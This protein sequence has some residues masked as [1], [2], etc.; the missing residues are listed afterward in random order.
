MCL[1]ITVADGRVLVGNFICLDKQGNII[2][3]QTVERYA[4]DGNT[5]EVLLGQ[6]LVPAKQ[7]V[8]CELEILESE[9]SDVEA[10]IAIDRPPCSTHIV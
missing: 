3:D 8:G 7:R 9:R 5:E 4:V 6:V 10:L 1:Q 2:L